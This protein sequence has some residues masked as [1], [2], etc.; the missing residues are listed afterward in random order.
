MGPQ[1]ISSLGLFAA[2]L[3]LLL[4]AGL[5]VG[6]SLGLGRRILVAALRAAVQLTLLGYLLGPL[7]RAQSLALTLAFVGA[8]VVL[9]AIEGSRRVSVS[10]RGMKRD[11]LFSL[12]FAASVTSYVGTNFAVQVSPWWE[13]RYL[14][15]FV[16]MILGNSLTGV[17]LGLD[18]FLSSLREQSSQV[19]LFL[20][21]GAYPSEAV[22]PQVTEAVRSGMI[23]I[24]NTLSV[25]GLVTIPG[26]MT[27]QLLG[28][29]P[30][31]LA[32][33]YQLVI[34]FLVA[35]ATALGVAS[36]VL[37]ARRR[38]FDR[39]GRLLTDSL[40]ESKLGKS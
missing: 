7:F 28:G 21:W 31:M 13:P 30:P 29:T 37:L 24:L 27:G 15:P 17:S 18:R 38:V 19:E 22:R 39:Q 20:A 2:A 34:L 11:A 35:G 26:M 3:L 1:E 40:M 14:I 23:P 32:A 25:V 4:N 12:L 5:S 8:M 9:S 16:G 33:R 36:S 6:L 10:Y